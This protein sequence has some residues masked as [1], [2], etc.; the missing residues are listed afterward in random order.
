MRAALALLLACGCAHAAK[1]LT[2]AELSSVSGGDGISFA[3][4]LELNQ[5]NTAQ[6][7]SRI[8][9]GQ[10]VDGRTTWTVLRNPSG[11]VDMVGLN[12]SAQTAAD[13]TAYVALTMPSY[14][15]FTNFGIDSLSVQSDPNAPVTDNMG[16]FT[17]NGSLQMTGQIRSWAH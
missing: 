14:V 5:Y 10:T 12:L 9:L 17:L 3:V 8:A 15:K 4:H 11:V 7:D 6:S 2:D 1:P 16:R 13:G